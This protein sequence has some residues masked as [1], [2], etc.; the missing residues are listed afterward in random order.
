MLIVL[1]E[2]P[3]L[4]LGRTQAGVHTEIPVET[5]PR[6]L[7]QGGGSP[8]LSGCRRGLRHHHGAKSEHMLP[9]LPL[10]TGENG[11]NSSF[12]QLLVCNKLSPRSS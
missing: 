11:T 4:E 7:L 5:Q 9:T 8:T 10:W 12:N 1:R 2:G 6:E 3:H